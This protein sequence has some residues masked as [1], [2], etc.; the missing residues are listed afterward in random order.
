[1]PCIKPANEHLGHQLLFPRALVQ[2][3]GEPAAGTAGAPTGAPKDLFGALGME[4]LSF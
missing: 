4:K 3:K 1:M 2:S